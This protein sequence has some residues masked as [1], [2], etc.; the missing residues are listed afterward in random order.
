MLAPEMTVTI[1]SSSK[2]YDKAERLART[3]AGQ[4]V[5][6]FTPNFRFNEEHVEVS[7]MEKFALTTDFLAKIR[8]STHVY[9]VAE[10][11]YTGTSVCIEVGYAYALG[12]KIVASETPTEPAVEALVAEVVSLD[13]FANDPASARVK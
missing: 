12:K 4:G 9:V 3:L 13:A 1:C 6:V 11:G 2:F 8:E 7:R 10:R 5:T